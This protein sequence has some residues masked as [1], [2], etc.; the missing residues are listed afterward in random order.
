MCEE[1]ALEKCKRLRNNY[2]SIT[3]VVEQLSVMD[4]KCGPKERGEINHWEWSV[5]VCVCL[6][7]GYLT[8]LSVQE[9][10]LVYILFW[11]L[12]FKALNYV[13]PQYMEFCHA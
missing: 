12:Q 13:Q 1:F 8:T 3:I 7:G 5:C 10:Q 4:V 11:Y 6:C 9:L 2:G